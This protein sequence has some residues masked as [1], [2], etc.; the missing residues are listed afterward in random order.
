MKKA[1]ILWVVLFTFFISLEYGITRP[2]S[3]SLFLEA[4]S[5]KMVPYAWIILVPFNLL[6]VAIYD[7]LL[8]KLG[9]LK[10]LIAISA[11]IAFINLSCSFFVDICKPLIFFQFV[12]K[13]VYIL[14]MFKQIWSLI[15]TTIDSTKAKFLYGLFFGIGSLGSVIGGLISGF[16]AITFT[17]SKLFIFSLPLYFFI[18]LFYF[19]AK[20]KSLL[21][22]ESFGDKETHGFSLIGASKPLKLVLLIV[23][24]MQ[25]SIAIADYQFNIA[26]EKYIP[27]VDART[28]YAGRLLGIVNGFS[29][30]FQ[31]VGGF[32]LIN[33][34]G[35]KMSHILVPCFLSINSLFFLIYPTFF[36]ISYAFAAI[37]SVDYSLFGM[38]KEMLYLP[39][40]L[41]EKFRAKAIIDVFAYRTAKAFASFLLLS[42]QFLIG[43]KIFYFSGIL[44][45]L[46]AAAWISLILLMFKYYEQKAAI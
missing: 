40:D 17:S 25:L 5:S 4:Y 41:K 12:W 36:S 23:I 34:L 11:S 16:F 33:F 9:C 45:I 32:L 35:L 42:L 30:L 24:F 28:E 3:V 19:M 21:T 29:L 39:M 15:H 13:D 26:L 7:R 44:S 20:K 18:V 31:L 2:A 37:K 1:F 27:N 38:I 46:V 14:L 43:D 8:L 10:T 6:I 22:T